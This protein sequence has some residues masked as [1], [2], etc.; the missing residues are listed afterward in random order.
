MENSLNK[1]AL[2]SLW[3]T[4]D[5]ERSFSAMTGAVKQASKEECLLVCFPECAL[6][7]LPEADDY[8]SDIELA[9][10]IPGKTTDEMAVLA[11]EYNLC[12]SAGL[13]EREDEKLYDTAVLF[14][15]KGEIILKYRRINPKWH[16]PNVPKDLYVEGSELNTISTRFGV[17]AFAICGDMFDDSVVAK[18]QR[19]KPDYLIIPL[20]RSFSNY[21][22]DWWE[23]EEK[24]VYTQQVAQMGITS[25]L[26]NSFETEGKWPSF[27]GSM[28]VSSEG[29]IIAETPTGEPSFLVGE[30]PKIP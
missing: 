24:W 1:V 27:G 2:V 9:V 12:I 3:A 6:S 13:L 22:R 7:G 18:I 16:S 14:N 15:D 29:Q 10:E 30:I 21:S 26:M 19:A 4:S 5:T 11:K 28:V 25:F 23:K 8:E 17:L 20:S